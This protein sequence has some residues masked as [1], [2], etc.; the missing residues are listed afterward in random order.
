MTH[1]LLQPV[2]NEEARVQSVNRGT[3]VVKRFRPQAA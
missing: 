1:C 3:T 2:Q